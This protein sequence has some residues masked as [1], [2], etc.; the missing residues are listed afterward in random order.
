MKELVFILLGL[1]GGSVIAL[2]IKTFTKKKDSSS[3]GKIFKE[4]FKGFAKWNEAKDKANEDLEVK[5]NEIK[6][7][8]DTELADDVNR[9][10]RKRRGNTK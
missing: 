1:V 4:L 7:M 3:T 5:R 2:L 6:K 9:K 10:L 8:S